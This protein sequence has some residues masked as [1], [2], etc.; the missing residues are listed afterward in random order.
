MSENTT[1]EAAMTNTRILGIGPS[2]STTST[3]LG[4]MTL[5]TLGYVYIQHQ[6]TRKHVSDEHEKTREHITKKNEEIKKLIRPDE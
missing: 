6:R 3:T 5:A 2:I 4:V 1:D